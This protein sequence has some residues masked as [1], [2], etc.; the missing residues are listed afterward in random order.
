MTFGIMTLIK[1][2]LSIHQNAQNAIEHT[3]IHQFVGFACSLFTF[4]LSVIYGLILQITL[5]SFGKVAFC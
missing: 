2:I 3:Y 4:L 5:M 1:M